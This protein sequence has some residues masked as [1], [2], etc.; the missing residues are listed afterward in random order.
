MFDFI[1]QLG[2]FQFFSV[3]NIVTKKYFVSR[4]LSTQFL[5]RLGMIHKFYIR[6]N[7]F[8]A[9]SLSLAIFWMQDKQFKV[10]VRKYYHLFRIRYETIREFGKPRLFQALN[11]KTKV[12][13]FWLW[14]KLPWDKHL[15]TADEPISQCSLNFNIPLPWLLMTKW[16]STLILTFFVFAV[17]ELWSLIDRNICKEWGRSKSLIAPF[18]LQKTQLAVYLTARSLF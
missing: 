8:I 11:P 10:N 5:V 6:V 7:I 17:Q 3:P 1:L 13:I 9:I 15:A 14:P 4:H 2:R 12:D 16:W 18:K